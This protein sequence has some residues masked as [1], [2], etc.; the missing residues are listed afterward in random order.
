MGEIKRGVDGALVPVEVD[1]QTVYLSAE[2]I[3][4]PGDEEEEIGWR[5]PSLDQALDG[6]MGVARTVGSRLQDS[7]ATR[8][9]VE[10][11]CEFVLESG[12]FIAV[13]GKA[14]GKSAFKVTLE[15]SKTET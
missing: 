14:S 7:D 9:A 4:G 12:S 13:L 15:W 5:P 10:F 2:E 1:G 8:V 3:G 6:L 11:G